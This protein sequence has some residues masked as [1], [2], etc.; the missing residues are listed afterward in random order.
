MA[1]VFKPS[2]NTYARLSIFGAVFAIGGLLFASA[3][4]MRSDYMTRAK[5][6][7]EQPVPFS[8]KIH[9]GQLGMDCRYC[10]SF[11]EESGHAN[12][13]ATTI[14]AISIRPFRSG[15]VILRRAPGL[16][17]RTRR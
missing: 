9:A 12:V 13:P 8:H 6:A 2:A 10:H 14:S 16:P 4:F 11:V 7:R 3:A 1:Q 15:S 17:G 5:S